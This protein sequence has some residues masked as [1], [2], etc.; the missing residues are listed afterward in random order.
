MR[1]VT[2]LFAIALAACLL[3]AA[4]FADDQGDLATGAANELSV[5]ADSGLVPMHRLYNAY[6]AEH[7][8]TMSAGERDDLAKLG[9]HDGGIGWYGV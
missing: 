6:G 7:H 5:Q 3:P 9:W 1:K 4:A 2:F 8:Y